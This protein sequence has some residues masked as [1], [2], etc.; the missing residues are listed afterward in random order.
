MKSEVRR[1]VGR[2]WAL[3]VGLVVALGS[4]LAACGSSD[5]STSAGTAGAS[6][7][8]SGGTQTTAG[9]SSDANVGTQAQPIELKVGALNFSMDKYCG[10]KPMKIGLL[11]GFGGNTW[12]LEVRAVNEKFKQT[13]KNVN[14]VQYFDANLDQQKYTNAI[15]SWAAQGFNV[16]QAY[17]DFGPLTVPAFRQAQRQGVKVGS[18]NSPIGNV[19]P[20]AVSASVVQNLDDAGQ[21]FVKFLDDAGNGKTMKILL[22]GGPA[23]NSQDPAIIAAMQKAIK[24][25]GAHVEFL[26]NRL[27][28]GNWDTATTQKAMAA[29]VAK[30]PKIDGV[31]DTYMATSPAVIRA[32]KAAGR[33]LPAIA[34]QGSTMQVVCQLHDERKADPK[35]NMFSID[36]SGNASPMALAKAIAAYQGIE[37]P[38]LGPSDAPTYVNFP[39]YVDTLNNKIPAC[40]KSVP[41]DADLS[42]PLSPAEVSALKK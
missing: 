2:R 10:D 40:D 11:D 1:L 21:K 29:A 24:D 12:R 3:T 42:M 37:A 5:N 27:V 32:F 22:V 4:V 8:A 34:G 9:A 6:T 23:S 20:D 19:V 25:T 36:A 7:A 17:P 26:Q 38:E 41:A 30:Y 13:C 16:I 33:P 28:V 35:F 39:V 31:V 15:S 18:S 14:E